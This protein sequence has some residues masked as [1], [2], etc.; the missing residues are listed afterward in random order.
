LSGKSKEGGRADGEQKLSLSMT[1]K[2]GGT[3]RDYLE[4]FPLEAKIADVAPGLTVSYAEPEM[5]VG[6]YL[7]R[8]PYRSQGRFKQSHLG[9]PDPKVPTIPRQTASN[10]TNDREHCEHFRE[11]RCIINGVWI[12]Q[13]MIDRCANRPDLRSHQPTAQSEQVHSEGVMTSGT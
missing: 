8:Y 6:E 3:V 11:E 1:T 4:V 5:T 13:C 7:K 2:V 9:F 12:G 10:W